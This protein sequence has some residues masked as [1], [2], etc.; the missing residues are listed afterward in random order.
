MY[1]THYLGHT[2]MIFVSIHAMKYV[3]LYLKVNRFLGS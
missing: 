1:V 3:I 2:Y